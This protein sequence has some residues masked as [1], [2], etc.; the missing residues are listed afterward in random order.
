MKHY[1]KDYNLC[2]DELEDKYDPE[3]Q[4]NGHP[5]YPVYN[6][7]QEVK[8]TVTR[9]GYWEWVYFKLTCEMEDL[10]QS[11]PHTQWARDMQL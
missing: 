2:S 11:N 4:G 7:I 9:M 6:W 5:G 3:I 1:I 10:D 8:C